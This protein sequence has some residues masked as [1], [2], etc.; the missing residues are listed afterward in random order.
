MCIGERIRYFRLQKQMTQEKLA[1]EVNVS[2]QAVSKWERRESLPDITLVARIAA[3][4]GVSCDALL[5]E[6]D[7][8][9]RRA[10]EAILEDAK[11]YDLTAYDSYRRCVELLESAVERYPQS[12]PLYQALAEVYSKGGN[13]PEYAEYAARAVQ[14]EEYILAHA[15]DAGTRYETVAILC[16]LYRGRGEYAKIRALADDMPE[17]WQSRPALLHHAMAGKAQLDGIHDLL[18]ELL[19]MT[20]SYFHQLV[21]T[22][23]AKTC[24]AIRILRES[25]E[26]RTQWNTARYE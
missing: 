17:L 20:E 14:M 8:F 22:P 11:R 25:L 21:G 1:A 12:L 15:P 13:Y 9:T 26:D 16:S 19:A 7:L 10:V 18:A 2:Y 6:D 23:D 3:V 4:L 24:E 5:A